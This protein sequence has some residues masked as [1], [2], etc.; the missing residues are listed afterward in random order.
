M[1]DSE[2]LKNLE[3]QLQATDESIEKQ[4]AAV[5]KQK[6]LVKQ[7]NQSRKDA[8]AAFQEAITNAEQTTIKQQEMLHLLAQE[9]IKAVSLKEDWNALKR[10][11]AIDELYAK[12]PEVWDVLP[13][14]MRAHQE[15]HESNLVGIDEKEVDIDELVANWR[16]SES[17]TRP[18]FSHWHVEFRSMKGNYL[19]AVKRVCEMSVDAQQIPL[20]V[21]Q[22]PNKIID[23]WLLRPEIMQLWSR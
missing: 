17:S 10:K 18:N 19:A 11:M 15:H 20:N 14:R 9:K 7:A 3:E 4:S 16:S 1:N 8:E 22:Q 6:A 21:R 13:K 23:G 12:Q 2:K 5:N